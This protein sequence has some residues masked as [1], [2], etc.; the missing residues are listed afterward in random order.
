MSTSYVSAAIVLIALHEFADIVV[1]TEVVAWSQQRARVVRV[2]FTDSSF[3]DVR[4]TQRGDYS[5]HWEHRMVDGGIH[6]WD[7]APHH[8]D[9]AT[10]PNHLHEGTE[11]QVVSSPLPFA[12]IE[13]SVRHVLKSIAPVV[14]A[15][16][17]RL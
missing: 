13:D 5:F 8:P 7:N 14:R 9:I 4:M 15:N 2:R 6:R 17:D 1:E 12:S 16:A 3:L 10:Y 11:D